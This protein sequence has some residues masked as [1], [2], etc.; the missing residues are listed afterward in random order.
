MPEIS[1]VSVCVFIPNEYVAKYFLNSAL[2][3]IIAFI[4]I[5]NEDLV[6]GASEKMT[7]NHN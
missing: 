1:N 3:K 5:E 2:F 7:S 6:R 4:S